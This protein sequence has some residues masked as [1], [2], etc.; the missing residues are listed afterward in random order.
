MKITA[1]AP[2]HITVK[3]IGAQCNL[4]CDYCFY[5]EKKALYPDKKAVKH[6]MSEDVLETLIRNQIQSRAVGQNKVQFAWQGGEPTLMGI[7]FF[8]KVVAFQRK[9]APKNVLVSNAFQTNGVLVSDE[10]AR[11]FHDNQFLVGISIDGPEHLHDHFRRDAS[12]RGSFK[13]V[14]NGIEQ[15]NRHRVEY[16]LLTVVQSDNSRYPDEV[17]RFLSGLGSQFIQFIPIVEPDPLTTVNSRSV[18]PTQ[19]GQFL[20]QVFHLWRI[21][22]IGRIYVQY[23]EM[24]LGLTLELPASLCVHAP[25]CGRGLA[26][27]HNGD[28]YSCDHYV[29]RDHFLGNI[30]TKMMAEMADS[31]FQIT[32]G[33]DKSAMLPDACRYC[34]FLNFCHGGCPK[35]RLIATESG[36]LNWLCS[37][38]KAF[39]QETVPYFSA[40]ATVLQQGL[41]ASEYTRFVGL[42]KK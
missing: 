25:T 37:G 38:Y 35:D 1:R 24:L 8:E 32:F 3:P 28:L 18:R 31:P 21:K 41:S 39:Y 16:N 14:M 2:F 26:L 23:F 11:F 27:E 22:D 10:F 36:R 29:D 20:N 19:W 15:L 34:Q 13:A 9:Y 42:R 33:Q 7:P 6:R 30:T 4:R 5:L 12:G 17:Y 40:M